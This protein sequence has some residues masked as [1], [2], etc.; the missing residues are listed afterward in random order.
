MRFTPHEA[1]QHIRESLIQ[2]LE[3]QYKI[4]NTQIFQERGSLLRTGSKIAQVPFI[5]ATPSFS[6]VHFLSELEANHPGQITP[7]LSDLVRHGVPVDRH[8]LYIHQEEALLATFSENPNLLVATGTGSGKTESFLLP[9]LAKILA[10]A[11][12]WTRPTGEDLLGTYDAEAQTWLHSR[13][14]ETRPPALRSIILYPM[15]ALVNDQLTRLRRIL[16]LGNSPV[17]QR[18]NLNGNVIHFGMY[19]SLTPIAG[20]WEDEWRREEIDRFLQEVQLDWDNLPEHHQELGGWPRPNASE[21]LTRWDMQMAPPDIL[22]TNYSML[23]YML[24]RPVEGSIFDLT[25][26]W[27]E[28]DPNA[29]F[30]LVLDEAHTYSGAKGTEVAHLIRRLRERLGLLSEDAPFQAIATTASVP[31]G[32]DDSLKQFT[33]DLFGVPAGSFQLIRATAQ[34]ENRDRSDDG[35]LGAFVRFQQTFELNDSRPAISALAADFGKTADFSL[36]EEVALFYIISDNPYLLW[37][38]NN[39]ARNATPL[40]EIS[41]SCWNGQG[42]LELREVATAG[43][44]AAGSFARADQ[45]KGTPPLLSMRLHAFFRG[46]P[47]LWACMDQN[48]SACTEQNNRPVG[49]I[50]TEPRLWCEC[51]AR[52]LEVF[53]CRHCG[54]MFLG[55][56][57]DSHLGSL[58][59]WSDNLSGGNNEVGEFRIFGVERPDEDAVPSYRSIRSTLIV[60]DRAENRRPVYEVTHAVDADGHMISP[61][62][63]QCPRCQK[64]R[65]PGVDGREVIEPLR[66]KGIQSFATIVEE[67]FRYQI[68]ATSEEPNF[69]R[70]ALLFSDSRREASKLASDLKEHHY[71][72][73]FRQVLY[74]VLYACTVCNGN[75]YELVE[76]SGPPKIGRPITKEK[77]TCRT[78][79]G[80]KSNP[81]PVPMGYQDL[82]QRVL[83][84]QFTRGID[85]SRQ[86]IK[87]IFSK[88]EQSW[89]ETLQAAELFFNADMLREVTDEVF[90]F[91]PLAL[92]YWQVPT[93]YN[94]QPYDDVGTFDPLTEDESRLLIQLAIRLLSTERV[95]TAPAPR[96]PWDW[97]K[98][99]DNLDIVPLHR[100]NTTQRLSG[101]VDLEWRGRVMPF[102]VSEY[103]KLGRFIVALSYRLLELG[104]LPENA[105]RENWVN[106]LDNLLWGALTNF[107]ILSHAGRRFTSRGHSLVPMGIKL[108]QFVLHPFTSE[109]IDECQSCKYVMAHA[110]LNVCLRCGQATQPVPVRG[111]RN[112][113]RMAARHARPDTDLLDPYPFRVSEHTAQV[114]STEARNEERWFQDVFHEDQNHLDHRVDALS[115]TTTMEMGIDIGSLLFVGL[116][117]VPPTVANYQQRAGRAGRRGSALAT[118]FTFAQPRSHDQYYYERPKQIISDMPRVPSLNIVNG[119]IARRHFRS[120]ILQRFFSNQELAGV[121]LF[122]IWGT[123]AN[124]IDSDLHTLLIQFIE[125]NREELG[126]RCTRILHSDL[127][128][129][130]D[131]WLRT[132]PGEIT[133]FVEGIEGNKQLFEALL[134]SGMLP[135]YAFPVDVVS[136]TIPSDEGGA[137]ESNESGEVMQRDLKI[138]I[139]EYAP[140]AEVTKQSNQRTYKYQSVGLHDPFERAPRYVSEGLVVECR[141]CQNVIVTTSELGNE[142]RVCTVCQ[143][144]DI[145]RMDYIRPR[146]FTVDGALP[147]GGRQPYN[148]IDGVE[149]G[150]AMAP[151]RL[152]MG[153]NSFSSPSR[154]SFF[155]DRLLVVVNVGD[156]L[157]VNRGSDRNFPGFSLCPTCGRQLDPN[158]FE[159]HRRPADVPPHRGRRQGPRRGDIC[160]FQPPYHQQRVLLSHRFHSEVLLLGVSL[161]VTMDAPFRSASGTAIWFSFGTLIA[162]AAARFLQIDA[163]ELKVGARPVNRGGSRVHAE[164]FIYDDVSGGAGYARAIQNNLDSIFRLALQLG[165]SCTNLE[166]TGACYQCLL[167]YRNQSLHALLDRD[168]GWALLNYVI[169]GEEPVLSQDQIE[170]S[171]VGLIDYARADYQIQQGQVIAGVYHPLLL[172]DALGRTI[173]IHVIHPLVSAPPDEVIEGL[174]IDTGF[175]FRVFTSFDLLTRPFWVLNR[176]SNGAWNH[177]IG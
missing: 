165:S 113:F 3:T 100:R 140:G 7:G 58:W 45:N 46:V 128:H 148:P 101:V 38:R 54:L 87:D 84:L 111:L 103:R 91:E 1:Y 149:R 24:M 138:A 154:Q 32:E 96:S 123:V 160:P 52:I 55:G 152:M 155:N 139:S 86:R 9:I 95:V 33:G 8:R 10:E 56:I 141:S 81:D 50:Y 68:P 167:D 63:M 102:N 57:P 72:D 17:W 116:R 158:D 16:S 69:G 173:A 88:A 170:Q 146:G 161:P 35:S 164:I 104:R 143:H 118:V 135:K 171:V 157:M 70:K 26:Q 98:D 60:Q 145:V 106:D 147:G 64:Y 61:F 136:L 89:E 43:L 172:G 144:T 90:S 40:T 79:N 25:R 107:G 94:G 124:Y 150:A 31:R 114:S 110:L 131:G 162:N 75:G 99:E 37:V 71:N 168:L 22:V 39:T 169:N 119:V 117:N 66:T 49:K 156:L 130:I 76:S 29:H 34:I 4:S 115:V 132:L 85:P 142:I 20:T 62:P 48:C 177:S 28:T 109:T 47:G 166:C 92:G 105:A 13:R 174:Q 137:I 23:E 122:N 82:K 78:C 73:L 127:H 134:N 11:R 93:L 19:T 121:T 125:E 2:Y 120:M 159:R 21:M 44:L 65:Q 53:T 74:N 83:E 41:E 5:E 133:T 15:N 36:G 77:V 151:V 176:I 14:S 12:N 97:G 59:P 80:A 42:T 30:T 126:R 112:Y 18:A 67:S 175:E 51:G 163:N 129:H 153:E 108:N 6:S 27:I